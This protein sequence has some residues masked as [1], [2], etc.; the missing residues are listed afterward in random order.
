MKKYNTIGRCIVRLC[1]I[2]YDYNSFVRIV[3]RSMEE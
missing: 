1:K 3:I 2:R